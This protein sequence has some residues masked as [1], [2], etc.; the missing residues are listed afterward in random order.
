MRWLF[1]ILINFY[2]I[3]KD[4]LITL[5]KQERKMPRKKI[6]TRK[7]R[8]LTPTEIEYLI[9]GVVALDDNL[10]EE[11]GGYEPHQLRSMAIARR[12]LQGLYKNLAI[13]EE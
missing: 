10:E 8:R 4:G 11:S 12:D 6:I 3:V 1:A 2:N 7:V 13:I 5:K 9:V